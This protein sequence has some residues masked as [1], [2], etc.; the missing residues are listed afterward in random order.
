MELRIRLLGAVE[1]HAQDGPTPLG[2]PKERLTLAALAWDAG[3]PVS[4]DTLVHRIWDEALPEKPRDALY[5]HISR[6]R[7]ALHRVAGPKAPR[8]RS[9]THAY[10]LE[11]DPDTV[12]LRHYLRL[13][14]EA[15][16]LAEAGE[17]EG[18]LRGL[19]QAATLR[20]GPPLTGLN[21]A[22][23][24][25]LRQVVEE[26]HLAAALLGADLTLRRGHFTTT[27]AALR[28]LAELHGAKQSFAS[29]M[30]LALHGCG[31]TDEAARLLHQTRHQLLHTSGTDPGEEFR[32]VHQGVLAGSPVEELL[33]PRVR[34]LPVRQPVRAP[35]NLPRHVPCVGRRKELDLLTATLLGDDTLDATDLVIT[36][37]PGSGKSAVALD[38]AHR[39]RTRFPD[40]QLLV[41]LHGHTPG[42]APKS[43]TQ[44]LHEL[45]RPLLPDDTPLPE[46]L[47]A[48]V[49]RWRALAQHR[50]LLVVLDDAV[51]LHQVAPL[52][53]GEG[54]TRVLVTSR[55]RMTGLPGVPTLALDV[56]PREGS[57]AL[58]RHVLGEERAPDEADADTLAR[59]CADLPLALILAARRLLSRPAWSAVD[60]VR[61]LSGTHRRLP[62]IRAQ[63]DAVTQAF[64]VSYL[65]L[66][67]TQ[68]L[69]FRR[70][71][72]HLGP[73]FGAEAT[74]A[75]CGLSPQETEHVL[76]ELLACCLL[77]EHAPHR[78][79]VHDLLR[80]YATTLAEADGT[81]EN[82]QAHNRLLL[83]YL[84]TADRADRVAY[85]HRLRL[86]VPHADA[87]T[88]PADDA[89][90]W[91]ITEGP[92][93]LAAL[94]YLRSRGTGRQLAYLAHTLTG[95]LEAEGYLTTALPRLEAAVDHWRETGDLSS[96]GR[97]LIDLCAVCSS[98]GRYDQALDCAHQ[99]RRWAEDHGDQALLAEALHHLSIIH[100]HTARYPEALDLQQR[101][102][103]LRLAGPDR[104]QQGRSFNAL[105]MICLALERHRESLRYFLEARTRFR[106]VG[107][108][109]GEGTALH[110]LAELYKECGHLD[111]AITTYQQALRHSDT[112]GGT[113]THA[114]LQINLADA[115]CQ[116]GA[117]RQ[118]L[119]LYERALPTLR[120][121]GDRR[122]EAIAL[123]GVGQA[124]HALGDS[125]RAASHHAAALTLA[126][127][128][129]ATLEECQALRGLGEAEA[130]TGHRDKARLRL[131]ASLALSREINDRAE[132]ART[133]RSLTRLFPPA[134][135]DAD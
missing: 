41:H 105:G 126:R 1:L 77:L 4:V 56:L 71:G 103:T 67:E 80:E 63:H 39:L 86:D 3:R 97:A 52:L 130:A 82:R 11:V 111:D 72:L 49:S 55:Y 60:L 15:H 23:P 50:G 134:L 29:R 24:D 129:H 45:L 87:A 93:L 5:P 7:R 17:E 37:M 8:V 118:A 59:L 107:D 98:A 79:R 85:P 46:D 34:P 101:A 42:W 21:G 16:R 36:G 69:V 65:A 73:E 91:F 38:A 53:P 112:L 78:Y 25:H 81:S 102:L 92:N 127:T 121:G 100:W 35:D 119:A 131:R 90:R 75:L 14:E 6:V 12:D 76:E 22:W 113:S 40:G 31:R 57:V 99:A 109:R 128:I 84:R 66:S 108:R 120:S 30:A 115:L 28:P 13:L 74:A 133:L 124:L 96:A 32:H 110:N 18:A 54:P 27:V 104:L 48:L 43:A 88:P 106:E 68:R 20:G 132:E 51:D 9:R 83:Y 94:E 58:L 47:D 19:R 61:R 44:A 116:R 123:I 62:E 125:A 89:K 70:L 135:P 26:R 33:R 2:T 122:S 64:E 114:I 10:T 95:F 117:P